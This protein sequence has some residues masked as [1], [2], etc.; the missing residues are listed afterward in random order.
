MWGNCLGTVLF[1]KRVPFVKEPTF[2]IHKSC[3]VGAFSRSP[4]HTSSHRR[5]DT[6]EPERKWEM[7]RVWRKS[8][9]ERN[10]LMPFARKFQF[11]N[12]RLSQ[13]F[14][15]RG[16]N[17]FFNPGDLLRY[18]MKALRAG[19]NIEEFQGQK[20]LDF[21]VCTSSSVSV[22]MGCLDIC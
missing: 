3:Q 19:G 5:V 11:S 2:S 7:V 20:D 14:Q 17:I 10:V 15:Y 13:L 8:P 12:R 1:S 22:Y 6:G 9:Q 4:E 16:E 21:V 18:A